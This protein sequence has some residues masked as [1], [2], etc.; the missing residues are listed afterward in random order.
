[1]TFRHFYIDHFHGAGLQVNF[2]V[3]FL[4]T[5][6][7]IQPLFNTPHSLRFP[8]RVTIHLKTLTEKEA[9]L[10]GWRASL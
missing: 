9:T 7:L 8:I 4:C 1:M 6:P 5:M 10:M 2:A 3:V